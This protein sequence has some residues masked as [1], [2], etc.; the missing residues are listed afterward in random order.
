MAK[1]GSLIYDINDNKILLVKGKRANKWSF[2]KG[3]RE[4]GES[5]EECAIRETYE[6]TGLYL[7]AVVP[8]QCI[9]YLQKIT[10][11]KVTLYV[12]GIDRLVHA[13]N[14]NC[15]DKNEI[16]EVG[17]FNVNEIVK[18]LPECNIIVKTYVNRLPHLRVV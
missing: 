2:P 7:P 13:C 18:M 12:I 8:M 17:W 9:K 14:L 6:E 3:H 5:V 16:K 4:P 11:K 15:I 1:A 10:C